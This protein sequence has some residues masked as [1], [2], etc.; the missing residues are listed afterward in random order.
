M[1][2]EQPATGE[3][4]RSGEDQ[5]TGNNHGGAQNLLAEVTSRVELA[6]PKHNGP[7]VNGTNGSRVNGSKEPT[8]ADLANKFLNERTKNTHA[9]ATLGMTQLAAD[10]EK[11]SPNPNKPMIALTVGQSDQPA[12]LNAKQKLAQDIVEDPTL[13]K[14][15]AVNGTTKLRNLISKHY[16]E[17]KELDFDPHTEIIVGVGG[18]GAISMLFAATLEP[19]D[20]VIAPAPYW[21][22]YGPQT[23]FNGGIAVPVECSAEDEYKLTPDSLRTA[24]KEHKPKWVILNSPSNPT[25][26]IYTKEELRALANVLQ[27]P[28]NEDVLVMSDDMYQE[29]VYDG[30]KHTN[31]LEVAPELKNRVATLYAASKDFLLPGARVGWTAGP[32]WLIS[33]AKKNQSHYFS[34]TA[35]LSQR[36]VEHVLEGD[37][38][39]L[40][41]NRKLFEKRRDNAMENVHKSGFDAVNKPKGAFYIF[42]D[43]EK[44]VGGVTEAGEQINNSEDYAKALLKEERVAVVPGTDFGVENGIR[45]S[46]AVSRKTMNDAMERM[47]AFNEQLVK[48]KTAIAAR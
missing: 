11:Y 3:V 2:G 4:D 31:I 42:L 48:S 18:K 46:F 32:E 9:S 20:K 43:T 15:T 30:E 41:E 45:I 6:N 35:S 44:F 23:N 47:K 16:K 17:T 29:L 22:S 25:G 26:S 13:D 39:F 12:P 38:S 19:G 40:E 28:G 24:I 8:Q 7:G 5:G 27:E 14:Y 33:G 21:V 37:L 10:L 1:R 36:L 34:H